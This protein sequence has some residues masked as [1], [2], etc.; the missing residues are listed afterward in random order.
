MSAT[1]PSTTNLLARL[2][3]GGFMSRTDGPH[4]LRLIAGKLREWFGR[5]AKSFM[6][7]MEHAQTALIHACVDMAVLG[8]VSEPSKSAISTLPTE[9]RLLVEGVL[10]RIIP[11][12]ENDQRWTPALWKLKKL[13]TTAVTFSPTSI[14]KDEVATALRN[15]LSEVLPL[16]RAELV[17]ML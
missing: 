5:D 11:N 1:A 4:Q 15:V 16:L 17:K 7:Q 8:E 12:E 6:E 3:V 14:T 9:Q 13:V 2:F 10:G